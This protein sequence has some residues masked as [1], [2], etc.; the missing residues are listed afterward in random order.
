MDNEYY[1]VSDGFFTYY[2][3]VKTSEQKFALD[4]G[5]ALVSRGDIDLRTLAA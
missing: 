5:D 1:K 4:E 3:N 2:V